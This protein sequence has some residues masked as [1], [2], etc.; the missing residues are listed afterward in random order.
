MANKTNVL[1]SILILVIVV[2]GGIVV[3]SFL[4]KPA[5]TGY[6]VDKQ[7]EGVNLCVT[8]LLT[9][10]QQNGFIQIP[11]GNQ[12]LILVPYTPPAQTPTSEL[13]AQ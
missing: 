5:Y 10:L 9:Q 8:N 11:I 12:S 1:I 3:Y 2:L 7:V 6:V 4:V 13:V